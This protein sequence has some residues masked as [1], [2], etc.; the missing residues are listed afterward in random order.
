MTSIGN[1]AFSGCTGLTSIVVAADN[2]VYD[3][4]E[5]CNAIVE[6][7]SNKLLVG[8]NKTIIPNSVTSIDDWAF[9]ACIDMTSVMIPD[10]VTS[11]G[12]FAFYCC[13]GLSSVIIPSKVKT[14]EH[15]AFSNCSSLTAVTIPQGVT[16]IGYDAFREC[17][18]LT[19]VTIP[20][21]VTSI[22]GYAFR[23]CSGLTS[24]TIP[25][26]VTHLGDGVFW[27]CNGLTSVIIS[28]GIT[29][30]EEQ[31]FLGCSGLT[32]LII[33]NSV[34]SI[35]DR[36]FYGCDGLTSVTIPSSVTDLSFS[37]F[38]GCTGLTSIKVFWYHPF[39]IFDDVFSGVDKDDCILY[40]PQGTIPEYKSTPG[41]SEFVNILEF[42]GSDVK[43]VVAHLGAKVS[44]CDGNIIV[45]GIENHVPVGVYTLDGLLVKSAVGNVAFSL[46][47]G[48]YLV[49][50]GSETFKLKF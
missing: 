10:G 32:S 49:K 29:E 18:S 42:D 43:E 28:N 19:S 11:I 24:A 33:P 48:V 38:E 16:S 12:A 30:I 44:A 46:P 34:K 31:T 3:S 20:N 36:A 21:S 39:G 1:G 7:S 40:V 22:D 9:F 8:C 37:V 5:N 41:W 17:S 47:G 45:E 14:I 4:R 15:A 25:N 13:R 23:E 2:P 26:S 27:G 50:V 6:T 35:G